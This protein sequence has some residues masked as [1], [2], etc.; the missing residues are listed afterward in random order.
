MEKLFENKAISASVRITKS[1][2]GNLFIAR[3][4]AKSNAV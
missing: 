2:D 3:D 4:V 1:G